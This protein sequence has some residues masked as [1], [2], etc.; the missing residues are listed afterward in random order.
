M[1]TLNIQK[2]GLEIL[3]NCNRSC[4][5]CMRG[6]AQ[7]VYMER[8]TIEN[9]F[10]SPDYRIDEI[11]ELFFSGG[12]PTMNFEIINY[13]LEIIKRR[14]IKVRQVGTV[15]NGSIY[16]EE[17]VLLLNEIVKTFPMDVANT[18]RC[19]VRI[20]GDQFHPDID[21]D[22]LSSY[23]ELNRR[24]LAKIKYDLSI[25]R[26]IIAT[27][28]A[29]KNNLGNYPFDEGSLLRYPDVYKEFYTC[30]NY[31][32]DY[33]YLNALGYVFATAIGSYEQMD[34]NNLGNVNDGKSLVHILRLNS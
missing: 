2:L 17:L 25:I 20:S 33:I 8:K 34:K 28:N 3:R 18:E 5:H 14:K 26:K 12:E 23:M 24:G 30:G 4:P 1:I 7:K 16:S 19:F 6:P 32:T 10:D 9:F 15:I 21:K 13:L 22:I 29:L 27:G 11:S 31:S